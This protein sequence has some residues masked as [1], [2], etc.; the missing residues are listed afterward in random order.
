MNIAPLSTAPDEERAV[1]EVVQS[2]RA[3]RWLSSM[4]M[5]I[6][7][8]VESSATAALIRAASRRWRALAHAERLR[9]AGVM[10]VVAAGVHVILNG[11]LGDPAGRMWLGVPVA[12]IAFGALLLISSLDRGTS[13][14]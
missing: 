4:W 5:S 11:S 2:S 6:V 7:G 14:S 9:A 13:E 3:F 1:I 10:L 8:T 12:T